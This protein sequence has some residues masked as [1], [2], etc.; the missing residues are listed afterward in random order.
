MVR[1]MMLRVVLLVVLL[2]VVMPMAMSVT[3][4]RRRRKAR[5]DTQRGEANRRGA[6]L[7]PFI[8]NPSSVPIR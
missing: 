3:V 4:V 8:H 6:C 1:L 7:Q 2:L 5:C